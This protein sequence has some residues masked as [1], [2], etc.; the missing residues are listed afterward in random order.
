MYNDCISL[1][2]KLD[3][4]E[5][6]IVIFPEIVMQEQLVSQIKNWLMQKAMNGNNLKMYLK[7]V[8]NMLKK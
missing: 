4:M 2:E 6:D 1:L 3:E 5:I 7:S 8:M